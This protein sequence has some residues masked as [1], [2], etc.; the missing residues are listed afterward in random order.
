MFPA[1]VA[2]TDIRTCFWWTTLKLA[3]STDVNCILVL[4][5]MP[6][7]EYRRVV[8]ERRRGI[9]HKARE[10]DWSPFWRSI[11]SDQ[12]FI[13]RTYHTYAWNGWRQYD[14]KAYTF[15][16]FDLH[17]TWKGHGPIFDYIAPKRSSWD[18]VFYESFSSW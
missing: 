18:R 15:H 3:V 4:R 13:P 5:W 9:P 2:I 10:W 7:H 1:R 12:G 8:W 14:I 11:A 6:W 16:P 17:G